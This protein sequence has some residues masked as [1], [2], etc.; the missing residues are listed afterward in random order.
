MVR[1]LAALAL[2]T[3]IVWAGGFWDKKPYTEW[4]RQEIVKILTNSPWAKRYMIE[5]GGS[6]PAMPDLS[7]GGPGGYGGASPQTPGADPTGG[8]G[9]VG[10]GA[11][12]GL[13]GGGYEPGPRRQLTLIVRWHSALPV[14]QALVKNRLDEGAGTPEADLQGFLA[15][16]TEHYIVSVSGMPVSLAS[17][18]QA[19]PE[20]FKQQ[21][22]LTP[23]GKPPIQAQ[24]VQVLSDGE[25]G[26]IRLNFPRREAIAL[27]DKQVEVSLKLG[28]YKVKRT[29]KLKDMLMN[30]DLAL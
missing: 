28:R 8:G 6:E 27:D 9:G 2:A 13:G 19:D 16:E 30:G 1:S 18:A 7:G 17:E 10:R 21:A 29:F 14:K 15:P 12:G 24:D 22:L 11:P 20:Q 4:G 23:K 3:S 25:W 5:L 26:E